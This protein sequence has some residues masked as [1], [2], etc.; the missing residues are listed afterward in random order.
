[1]QS[2]IREQRNVLTM[3]F[4]CFA[5]YYLHIDTVFLGGK[6]PRN[7]TAGSRLDF[8]LLSKLGFS[9]ALNS[10]CAS[11]ATEP[12]AFCKSARTLLSS[13]TSWDSIRVPRVVFTH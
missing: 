4:Q 13:L 12:G 8:S 10:S 11:S 9:R 2:D 3:S 1:M 7:C 5:I 6:R